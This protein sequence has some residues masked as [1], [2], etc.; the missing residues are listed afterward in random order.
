MKSQRVCSRSAFTLIELLVVIAIIALL[1][2]LLLPALQKARDAAR[3]IVCANNVRQLGIGQLMY[4]SE[5][6][7]YTAGVNTSGWQGQLDG[8]ASYIGDRSAATPTTTWDWISPIV[9]DSAG[10]SPNRAERTKQIFETY[11]C[12]AAISRNTALF[13]GAGDIADFQNVL[14][15]RGYRTVSFLAPAAFHRYPNPTAAAKFMRGTTT[16]PN[17]WPLDH[18]QPV[19]LAPNFIPRLDMLGTQPSNKVLAAD[20]TRYLD[21]DQTLDF[22][23]GPAAYSFSSFADSGPIFVESTA[24]GKDGPGRPQNLP[25]SY[26]HG[27][28]DR[29]NV[30]YYDG[31]TRQMTKLESWTNPYPWYPGGSIFNG[32]RGTPES[33]AFIGGSIAKRRI[34]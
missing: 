13:G 28:K 1:V 7:E 19:A 32:T 8:G 29:I 9:G 23:I 25:L 27:S 34:P 33:N 26:R 16:T 22:D 6:K 11:G 24:Y 5:N 3:G 12:P 2:G 21:T 4:A 18:Q 10:M 17:H 14:G 31:S 30:A 20:G 15:S